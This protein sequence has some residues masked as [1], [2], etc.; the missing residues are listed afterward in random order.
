MSLL[1][2]GVKGRVVGI[3]RT[4]GDRMWETPLKGAG[5]VNVYAEP[6]RIFAATRGELYCLDPWSGD[7]LWHNKMK[8]LGYGLVS[9]GYDPV[10][11]TVQGALIAAQ[12]QAAAAAGAGGTAAVT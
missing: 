9:F 5:F 2:V 11:Q 7:I 12:Q 6:D 3:D 4:S 10:N 8:G 1:V